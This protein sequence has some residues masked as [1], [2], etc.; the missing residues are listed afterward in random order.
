MTE[1]TKDDAST[2]AEELNEELNEEELE[3]VAGGNYQ[4]VP[5]APC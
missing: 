2:K 1:K 3:K 4:A 5:T